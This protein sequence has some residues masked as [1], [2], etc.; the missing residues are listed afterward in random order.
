M[1]RSLDSLFRNLGAPPFSQPD[2]LEQALTH[3]SAG[4]HNNER[5]E[6]LGD[7]LLGF[8]IAE[9]LWQRFP[10]A[11]EGRLT[12]ARATLVKQ[13]SLATQAR[14]LELGE[15]LRMGS[16]E[17]RTGGHARDSILSDAFEALLGAYYL[18]R[19]FEPAKALIL[20]LFEAGLEQA[21]R[22]APVKDPKTRLQESLQAAQRDLPIYEV[23]D[24][25]GKPHERQFVVRCL[26]PDTAEEAQ[27]RGKSR[28]NAEQHAAETMLARLASQTTAA[29]NSSSGV[30]P[31][32]TV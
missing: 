4:S 3:R 28:R 11:D 16:G 23:I 14:L 17:I 2:L 30:Q 10:Q 18:D 13:E 9:V 31:A 20:R 27:G 5:L 15:Y 29:Q 24:V 8:V 12:R 19:G 1:T 25:S 32:R 21:G 6:F 22:T 26:L 7:A